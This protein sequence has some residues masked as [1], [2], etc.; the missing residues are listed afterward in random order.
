M[1]RKNR[2][3]Y[4]MNITDFLVIIIIGGLITNFAIDKISE[5][6]DINSE[7][8]INDLIS[9]IKSGNVKNQ[10]KVKELNSTIKDLL[11]KYNNLNM[12]LQA[13]ST[14]QQISQITSCNRHKSVPCGP[15]SPTLADR[16]PKSGCPNK[17]MDITWPQPINQNNKTTNEDKPLI[18][19]IDSIQVEN[20]KKT[21]LQERQNTENIEKEFI[22]A[23]NNAMTING[24]GDIINAELQKNNF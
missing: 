6:F 7:S 3:E 9:K 14:S 20:W 18:S 4:I 2:N 5:G 17:H 11:S 12:H 23:Y 24:L 15:P 13:H 10:K 1:K 22:E 16:P 21:Y 19:K 8:S